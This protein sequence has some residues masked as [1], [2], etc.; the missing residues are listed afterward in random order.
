MT[1]PP[2]PGVHTYRVIVSN[3]TGESDPAEV[4]TFIGIDDPGAPYNLNVEHDADACLVMLDWEAPEFGRRGGWFDSSSLSYRVVRQPG[5]KL[6]ANNL[7]ELS[8]EDEDLAEYGNYV[9]EVTARTDT[10]LGG[11]AVSDGIL[12]GSGTSLP[13]IEGWE[14]PNTYPTWEIVDNNADGHT[15]FI[16]HAFGHESNSCIGWNYTSTEVD[17]DESLYSAP[18]RLE[19]GRKYRASFWINEH[20]Y[21]SFSL[22][23]SYFYDLCK[24][25]LIK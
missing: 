6:L 18:V 5:G 7:K 24:P 11:T 10:A 23:F 14:D 21:G 20:V 17:V 3:S 2:T 13:I 4:S 15:I 19:K 22:D 25:K 1:P 16:K 8:F 12:I 9:Y